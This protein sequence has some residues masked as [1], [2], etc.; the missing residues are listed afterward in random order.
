MRFIIKKND[1]QNY[2]EIENKLRAVAID[3]HRLALVDLVDFN[4]ENQSLIDGVI[5]P[6]KGILE[7]KKLA[8][9]Y[10]EKEKP[11]DKTKYHTRWD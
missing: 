7:L 2:K 3:G 9:V 6:K 11:S 10:S 4:Y 5:I 1:N 8:D